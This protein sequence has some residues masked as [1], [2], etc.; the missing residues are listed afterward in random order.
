MASK[1]N[2]PKRKQHNQNASQ[3]TRSLSVR[4]KLLFGGITT[5]LFF[6]AAEFVLY[7]AGTKPLY[8]TEDPY[9]GFA[10]TP[11]FVGD[12]QLSTAPNKL[13]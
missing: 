1:R 2:K 8:L 6:L 11:L 13:A 3:R 12:A 7:V 4:K 5:C 10:S 9:V